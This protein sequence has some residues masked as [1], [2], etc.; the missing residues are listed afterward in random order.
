MEEMRIDIV[1]NFLSIDECHTITRHCKQLDW[2]IEEYDVYN[3][4]RYLSGMSANLDTKLR[5]SYDM[6][7]LS[8][9]KD[10]LGVDFRVIRAYINAWKS[11]EPSFPHV[12]A[13]HTTWPRQSD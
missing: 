2:N 6:K 1:D 13:C 11:N 12:D 4:E 10:I 9:A 5:E 7:I 3:D 8:T